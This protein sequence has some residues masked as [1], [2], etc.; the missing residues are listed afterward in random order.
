MSQENVE[1]VRGLFPAFNRRDITA[2]LGC[3][4]PDVEWVPIMAVLEG[5]VY[6]GHE[7]VKR[8]IEHLD[9]YWELFEVDAEEFRD[10]GDRVLALGRWRARGRAGGVGL[11]N[12][13][14]TWL[15]HFKAGKVGR[16][17]TFTDRD[18]GLKAARHRV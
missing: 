7:G 13:P 5:R 17:Q 16:L 1:T 3:L 12:E 9:E 8:W 14:G 15:L 4:D 6:R 18:E 2:L 10:L 11:D